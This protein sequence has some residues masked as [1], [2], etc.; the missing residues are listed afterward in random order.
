MTVNGAPIGDVGTNLDVFAEFGE[1]NTLFYVAAP[2]AVPGQSVTVR[3]AGGTSAA[4]GIDLDEAQRLGAAE[5]HEI[6]EADRL[7][8]NLA[9]LGVA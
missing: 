1:D 5:D 4:V 7:E 6:G 3:T 8:G 2:G 9:A